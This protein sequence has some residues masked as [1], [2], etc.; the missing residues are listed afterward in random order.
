MTAYD[1][2]L[3]VLNSLFNKDCTFVL[4]TSAENCPSQR[5][6][7]TYLCGRAFWIVTYA[8][9]N[10]VK[11]LRVNPNVSLCNDFY[12]F[13]GKAYDMGHPLEEKNG[14]IREKL[15][16][17]FEPWYFAHNNENDENMCYVKVELEEGFFHKD[18]IGYKVDFVEK[19]AKEMPF[20]P[21]AETI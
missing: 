21:L 10:K 7:D 11:E 6:V 12:T 18:G 1:K 15:I 4:A 3:E 16:K 19:Q 8:L 20:A 9:S 13:K 5:V 17:V 14:E 2:S